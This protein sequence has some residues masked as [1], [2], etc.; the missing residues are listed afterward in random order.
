[1][2]PPFGEVVDWQVLVHDALRLAAAFAL[3]LPAAWDRERSARSAGL[4]TFPLVAVGSC[5]YVLLA[6]GAYA[7]EAT[8][9]SRVLE[10]LITGIGFVGGGA[11][12]RHG[13][14]VQ[15]TATAASV[16]TMGA[17]GASVAYGRYEM[18]VLLSLASV[19]I[20]RGLRAFKSHP[21]EGGSAAS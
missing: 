2:H 16:W 12:L 21:P 14:T 5:A 18:A 20:L 4:R 6:R 10:G 15:G 1:M 3:A 11:I 19:A 13:S 7:G 17:V 9:Q 8:A